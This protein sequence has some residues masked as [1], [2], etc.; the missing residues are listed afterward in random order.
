ME[1]AN[2]KGPVTVSD[3]AKIVTSESTTSSSVTPLSEV[4]R[5]AV[6]LARTM[7]GVKDGATFINATTGW[8]IISPENL[9]A[10]YRAMGFLGFK[11]DKNKELIENAEKT[12]TAFFTSEAVGKTA[13]SA[14]GSKPLVSKKDIYVEWKRVL[15]D[16]NKRKAVHVTLSWGSFCQIPAMK[17]F[18]K[19][20]YIML[21]VLAPQAP[22]LIYKPAYFIGRT[23]EEGIKIV[24]QRYKIVLSVISI[25][26]PK[27]N[28]INQ[29]YK[30]MGNFIELTEDDIRKYREYMGGYATAT[31]VKMMTP[32]DIT[33]TIINKRHKALK[34]LVYAFPIN[35]FHLTRCWDYR[36]DRK[37]AAGMQKEKE[38]NKI[39]MQ[40]E[41]GV[42]VAPKSILSLKPSKMNPAGDRYDHENEELDLWWHTHKGIKVLIRYMKA[43]L[44]GGGVSGPDTRNRD[45]AAGT[46]SEMADILD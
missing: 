22:Q 45:F 24:E 37:K 4:T 5:N 21:D 34:L 35:A 13:E 31:S 20:M 40:I 39:I 43:T 2:E 46:V 26:K 3:E 16:C 18:L 30:T 38:I 42:N 23:L 32:A 15:D 28:W 14:L 29:S 10:A 12:T 17:S 27:E 7:G 36:R 6:A 44:G 1:D 33:S 25:L 8:F 9:V 19:E 11:N 41:T